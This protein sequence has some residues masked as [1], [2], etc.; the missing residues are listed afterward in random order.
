LII[1]SGSP[2]YHPAYDTTTLAEVRRYGEGIGYYPNSA[3]VIPDGV[4][5]AAGMPA[6]FCPCTGWRMAPP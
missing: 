1:A 4:F 2:Y 5:L 3:T 6:T